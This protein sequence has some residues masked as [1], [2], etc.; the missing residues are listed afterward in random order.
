MITFLAE[1]VNDSKSADAEAS[2]D[3]NRKFLRWFSLILVKWFPVFNI[4][5]IMKKLEEFPHL[6][7][8]T[9]R[10]Y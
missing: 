5:V 9:G 8:Q 3:C 1:A 4:C 7:E 10:F 2:A 6:R